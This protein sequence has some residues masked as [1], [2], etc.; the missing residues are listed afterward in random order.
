MPETFRPDQAHAAE[1]RRRTPVDLRFLLGRLAAGAVPGQSGPG[2]A[3]G[4]V[5]VPKPGAVTHA[6]RADVSEPSM[7]KDALQ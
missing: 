2:T 3:S 1:E 6:G 7:R 5:V 4:E